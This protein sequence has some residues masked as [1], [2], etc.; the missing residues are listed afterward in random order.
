MRALVDQLIAE[1]HRADDESR[2]DYRKRL[3]RYRSAATDSIKATESLGKL[4]PEL[5]EE[6]AEHIAAEKHYISYV[7]ELLSQEARYALSH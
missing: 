1:L 6:I 4:M 3:G 5:V 7:N 2:A